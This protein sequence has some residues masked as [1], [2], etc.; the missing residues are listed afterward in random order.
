MIGATV[1]GT[2]VSTSGAAVKPDSRVAAT[3]GTPLFY[4]VGYVADNPFWN[5]EGKGAAAAGALFHVTVRYE[6]PTTATDAGM[7]SIV[8]AALGTHPTGIAIDYTDKAMEA[9]VLKALSEHV[10]VVLY[11]NNR[12][13]AQSGGSTTNPAVTSLGF[14]GQN[15]HISGGVLANAFLPYLPKG[16]GTVLLA[17]AFPQAYV[18]TLR[19]DAIESVLHAAGYKTT[20]LNLGTDSVT[21]E[22]IIGAYLTAHKVV[23]FIGLSG[24]I[25]SD[26]AAMWVQKHNLSLPLATFDVDPQ[27]VALI[28]AVPSFDLALDQQPYLQ[29]Y[30]AVVNLALQAEDGFSPVQINTGSLL[31]TKQNLAQV[32]ELVNKGVD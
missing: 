24:D 15:E 29:G 25:E 1:L 27:T 13:E 12:F 32:T 21:D 30:F 18:L 9:P 2:W 5:A 11:N 14:S 10:N 3:S 31:V 28:K 7:I 17:N 26:A 20:I 6:A 19:A 8:D 22:S 4:V 16:G 23:G